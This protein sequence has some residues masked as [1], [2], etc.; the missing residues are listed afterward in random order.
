[1]FYARTE[2]LLFPLVLLFFVIGLIY[3]LFYPAIVNRRFR[4]NN[5]GTNITTTTLHSP[6]PTQ[7]PIL[8]LIIPAYQEEE[9]LPTMLQAAY[10][11][12]QSD[13][14]RALQDLAT[15][16]PKHSSSTLVVEW[17][18]VNDGSKDQT[19][20]VYEKFVQTR[21]TKPSSACH[22]H[23]W[24]LISFSKNCGKGAAVQAGMLAAQGVFC[25]MVDADGATDFGPGLE[26]LV[27]ALARKSRSDD[28]PI[29]LGSRAH[30]HSAPAGQ[31]RSLLRSFLMQA[32]HWCVLI[33]VGTSSIVDTQCGFKL[34][35]ETAARELFSHLHLQRWA[36]DTELLFLAATLRYP[37]I[38]VVVPWQE[39]EGSKLNTSPFNLALVSISML[40]DMICVRLCYALGLWNIHSRKHQLAVKSL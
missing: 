5:N 31:R 36:F 30:L 40:R 27:Q 1:M 12:L 4:L 22:H 9:R 10:S 32:F 33:F 35:H 18:V 15:V 25:L 24:K 20:R 21:T 8:T 39:I 19:S 29:L 2:W 23:L 34:F 14:C 28:T 6:T 3:F 16:L 11:Y 38:E 17:I 13:R 7:Q 37:L 26:A